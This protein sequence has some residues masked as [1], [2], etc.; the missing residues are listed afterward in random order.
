MKIRIF[1]SFCESTDAKETFERVCDSKMIAGYRT[2]FTLTDQEDYTHVII[3]NIAMPNIEHI[4]K[5]RVIGLA[6]EPPL[7]LQLTTE[8]VEYAK[9]YIGKYFIGQKYDLPEPFVEHIAYLWH[10]PPLSYI[11]VKNNIMSIMISRKTHAPGHKYRHELMKAILKTRLPIDIY[12]N[13]CAVYLFS[14]DNRFKGGFKEYEPYE[15]YKFHIAI[16]NFETNEYFSEKIMNPLLCSCVPVYL[17]CKNIENYFPGQ[18][19]RLTGNLMD[20][21]RIITDI[22]RNPE[23]YKKHIDLNSVKHKINLLRNIETIF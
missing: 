6:F 14:M 2:R 13:G 19:I 22:V 12:G 1:S 4:P 3:M 16:E 15:N 11:P 5:E 18:V 23:Q 10:C 7:Y 20:D 8:F 17:G 9:K 21:L